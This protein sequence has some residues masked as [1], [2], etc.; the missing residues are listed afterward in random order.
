MSLNFSF[1]L[2]LL[3]CILHDVY[4]YLKNYKGVKLYVLRPALE[5]IQI[6]LQ[7][8]Y[9]RTFI[10]MPYHGQFAPSH[11]DKMFFFVSTH[12]RVMFF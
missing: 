12:S 11:K 2:N 5:M 3:K 9:E 8:L 10:F 6:T 7:F 1:F 4:M